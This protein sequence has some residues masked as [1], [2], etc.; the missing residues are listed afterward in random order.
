ML[1]I[2]NY[3]EGIYRYSLNIKGNLLNIEKPLV[4][5]II[6]VTPDSFFAQSR[7]FDVDAVRRHVDRQLEEG[8]DI[9]DLGGY[10]SRPG[11]DVVSPEE[12]YH[13]LARGLEIIRKYHPDAIVSIDTFR[14]EVARRCV[15]DWEADI[16]NDI[17]GGDLDSQMWQI[18]ADLKVPYIVMHTRGTPET[19][20]SLCQYNDVTAD[21]IF[22]LSRKVSMLQDMGVNDI[23][24][25]PGF[26]FAKTLDQ[27]YRLFAE[28]EQF[29]VFGLPVLVGI[30]HKSMIYKLLA[31]SP[32]EALTGTVVLNT[33]A[34]LKGAAILR[35]HDVREAVEAV[36]IVEKLKNNIPNT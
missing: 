1:R 32:E 36:K 27:N 23:I 19:M 29:S 2:N 13:R 12:E 20:Q 8:A 15:M 5:G 18:V 11:A 14:A 35:V 33:V 28:L 31:T 9:I 7:A 4:M 30:S 3:N 16:I 6:N 24:I 25:D 10:S 34:L 22:E 17:S 26:G 21:V